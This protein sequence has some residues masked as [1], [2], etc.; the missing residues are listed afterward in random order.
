VSLK[1]TVIA[2]LSKIA[3][4]AKGSQRT[5][6]R[7]R[8]HLQLQDSKI[9]AHEKLASKYEHVHISPCIELVLSPSKSSFKEL[10]VLT[11]LRHQLATMSKAKSV[12]K[13]LK[14]QEVECRS[15]KK[16][17]PVPYVPVVD[18]VQDAV[19]K[20]KGKESTYTKY[21]ARQDPVHS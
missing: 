5:K 4:V 11:P 21:V 7:A 16:C 10:I 1:I 8:L 19:N 2:P 12:P 20:T 9:R 14:D 15:V 6:I 13:G 3:V 18:E 17:P